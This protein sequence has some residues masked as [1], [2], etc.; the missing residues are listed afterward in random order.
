M[1]TSGSKILDA[2]LPAHIL[3]VARLL[4]DG[5]VAVIPTD[6]I[7]ALAASIYREEAVDRIYQ[8]KNRPE[9]KRLPVL[10]ASAA[11]LPLLAREIPRPAWQLIS[12]YWPGALTLVL[13]ARPGLPQAIVEE[14][15]TVAVRVPGGRVCLELLQSIGEPLVGTSANVGGMPPANTAAE[16]AEQLGTLVDAILADDDSQVLGAPSTI[17]HVSETGAIVHREGAVGQS[18]IRNVLG[19]RVDKF[20]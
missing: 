6:T 5:G 16:A 9:D 4:R 15:N 17:V 7:Y 20:S 3:S 14:G 2:S 18:E 13:P 8:I 1:M 19:L 12:R 11:D 10:I